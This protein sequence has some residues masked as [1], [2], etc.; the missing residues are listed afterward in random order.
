MGAISVVN[1]MLKQPKLYPRDLYHM[2]RPPHP[3]WNHYHSAH[4]L[5]NNWD[6]WPH[7]VC[8]IPKPYHRTK[9]AEA[10]SYQIMSHIVSPP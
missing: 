7:G 6:P 2:N 8:A 4:C 10:I 3:L 1:D 9:T 5:V